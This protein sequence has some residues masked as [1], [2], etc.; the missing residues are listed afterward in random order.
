MQLNWGAFRN[1]RLLDEA[2]KEGF[3]VML[4]ADKSIK[5]QQRIKGRSIALIVLRASSNRRK[6][7]IPMMSE[8]IEILATIQPGEVVE[9]FE[10][11]IKP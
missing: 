9:V 11:L 7:H 10:E 4:T 1:G 2:E 6:T 5:T 8:V 3:T